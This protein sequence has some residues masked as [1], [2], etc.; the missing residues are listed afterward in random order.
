MCST[1]GCATLSASIGGLFGRL[2]KA[3]RDF[4]Y[5]SFCLECFGVTESHQVSP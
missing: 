3:E 1:R 5:F 2:P 4:S